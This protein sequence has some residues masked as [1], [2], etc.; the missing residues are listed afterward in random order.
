M[1]DQASIYEATE[2]DQLEVKNL[3]IKILKER[4]QPSAWELVQ[5]VEKTVGILARWAI[6]PSLRSLEHE[7]ER[8]SQD[9]TYIHSLLQSEDI[10]HAL[11]GTDS[12]SRQIVPSIDELLHHSLSHKGSKQFRE[13][14]NFMAKFR[15]YA[16]YNNMLVWIQ[17]PTCSFYATGRDWDKRFGRQLKEDA[18]PML[19]L[20]PMHPV[21]LVYAMDETDGPPLPERLQNFARFEGKFQ[22][23][24]IEKVIENAERDLIKVDFKK[25][26]S[27]NAG[28]AT[29]SRETDT[30]KL[31][32]AIHDELDEPSRFGVLCHELAHIYLGHLG[33]D[34]DHW[35]P[36]RQNLN[37]QTVEIEA[38]AAA[39]IVTTRL[40]LSGYSDAYLSGHLDKNELPASVSMDLIAKV[41]GKLDQMTKSVLPKRRERPQKK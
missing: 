37:H 23:D 34:K 17:D 8:T 22:K 39:Y 29:F 15:D 16:P 10:T 18:K 31:R 27:T 2:K 20:A 33:T 38:E 9:K 41:S 12:P 25:L 28:F 1:S 13:M 11:I 6:M 36:S 32:I 14:I 35:W 24:W 26:S 30:W 19:I 4:R 40:G 21:M 3:I 5:E 7:K